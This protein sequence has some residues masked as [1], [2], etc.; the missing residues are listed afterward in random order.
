MSWPSMMCCSAVVSAGYEQRRESRYQ[1]TE[2]LKERV[3]PICES[4]SCTAVLLLPQWLVV[5]S[6]A[7][8]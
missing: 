2:E 3:S 1:G 6:D 7:S 8:P 5:W 4:F